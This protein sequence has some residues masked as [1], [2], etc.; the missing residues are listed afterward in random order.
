VLVVDD[1]PM[2]NRIL[3]RILSQRGFEAITSLRSVGVSNLIVLH[4]P[5]LVLM[6]VMMPGLLGTSLVSLVREVPKIARTT[7]LL[8]SSL[9]DDFLLWKAKH[10]GAD[11]Y[12]LKSR[13]IAHLE[14]SLDH[15]LGRSRERRL[16]D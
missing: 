1:D 8:H 16:A 11:G 3:T 10:C 15:W 7:I 5:V 2:M 14:H 13:G 12:I 9:N 6:D 4:R